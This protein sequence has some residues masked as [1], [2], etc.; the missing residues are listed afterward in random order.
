MRL[1]SFYLYMAALIPMIIWGFSF[2]GM[3]IMYEVY[4]PFSTVFLRLLISSILLWIIARMMRIS[5]TIQ[6]KDKILF[7]LLTFFEP[8][9]YFLGESYGVLYTPATLASVI[10]AT[11]P[12]FTPLA[13]WIV[14]KER[15][16]FRAIAGILIS[17][18]GV[19]IMSVNKDL[20]FSAPLKGIAL[21]FFAVFSG[22][23]YGIIVRKLAHSYSPIT[24]VKMQNTFGALL[25]LPL[26]FLVESGAFITVVPSTKIIITLVLLA[27][28]ASTITFILFTMAVRGL[29]ISKANIFTNT[30][31]VFTAIFAFILVGESF[32]FQKVIGMVVV[33]GGL[34]LAQIKKPAPLPQTET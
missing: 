12:V 30:I 4:Q 33:I 26:V 31:P 20:S 27:V 34:F 5:E 13:A 25:F 17:F 11:I 32:S 16:T 10:I 19:I 28:F 15:I 8:F 18:I 2:V 23:G 22:I 24:I 1:K 29:G 9:C 14:L 3:K 7:I 21:L 6:A